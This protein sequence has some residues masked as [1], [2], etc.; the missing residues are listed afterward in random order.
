[1]LST[2]DAT[3]LTVAQ[4]GMKRREKTQVQPPTACIPLSIVSWVLCH[5]ASPFTNCPRCGDD[6]PILWVRWRVKWN[7]FSVCRRLNCSPGILPRDPCRAPSGVMNLLWG[8]KSWTPTEMI[9]RM[10]QGYRSMLCYHMYCFKF[11][12]SRHITECFATVY[13]LHLFLQRTE[14]CPAYS[15]FPVWVLREVLHSLS[16]IILWILYWGSSVDTGIVYGL[17]GR[18]SIPQGAR[19]LSSPQRPKKL[20]GPPSLPING[21]RRIFPRK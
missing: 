1:M 19:I 14:H 8:L 7:C 5:V 12:L 18:G 2:V 20:W 16:T 6:K 17:N 13:E 3:R 15:T 21:H 11:Y 9:I 10:D 4:R